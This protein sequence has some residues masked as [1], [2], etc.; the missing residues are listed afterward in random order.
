MTVSQTT[1]YVW[2]SRAGDTPAGLA[3]L[4]RD[5]AQRIRICGYDAAVRTTP[6]TVPDDFP[7]ATVSRPLRLNAAGPA[8]CSAVPPAVFSAST[9][10]RSP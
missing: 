1:A 7:A 5:A 10:P 6:V 3:A 8:T 9:R 4:C 2:Q